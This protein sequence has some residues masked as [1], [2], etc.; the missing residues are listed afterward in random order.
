VPLRAAAF[1]GQICGFAGQSW[2]RARAL[3]RRTAVA[4]GRLGAPPGRD[5][6][7]PHQVRASV[8]RIDGERHGGGRLPESR[9]CGRQAPA[10]TQA[11]A[12]AGRSST[13]ETQTAPER[14]GKLTT[15]G[16]ER[17]WFPR[18][19]GLGSGAGRVSR[20]VGSREAAR[21]VD[22]LFLIAAGP[23][24]GALYVHPLG[25][26]AGGLRLDYPQL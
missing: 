1:R 4:G 5:I 17:P 6:G 2:R 10:R 20:R 8:A 13:R 9:E 15:G 25:L 16:S 7:S 18:L 3:L 22:R 14:I 12:Q 24:A 26:A 11:K 21:A 19:G 23:L